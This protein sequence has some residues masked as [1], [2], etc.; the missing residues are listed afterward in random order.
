MGV[1]NQV[2]QT[3]AVTA[4]APVVDWNSAP[5][6]DLIHHIVTKHHEYLKLELPRVGQRVRTVVEVHGA[7]ETA[8][9]PELEEVYEELWQELNLHMHKEEIMLFPAIER[10]EAATQRGTTLPPP[11]FGGIRNPIAVMERE[12][13]SADAALGRIRELTSDFG[14]SSHACSTYSAML[15][16]LRALDADLHIHIRLENEILFPRAIALEEHISNTD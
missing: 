5:L 14:A 4:A 12:H 13:D 1:Q 9:L 10:F 6:R 16:G 15:E 7:K 3:A 11:P 2:A 8:T